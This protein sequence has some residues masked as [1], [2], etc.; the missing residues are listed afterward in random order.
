MKTLFLLGVFSLAFFGWADANR[1]IPI[2][3]EFEKPVLD[4]CSIDH[5]GN[6]WV[7][8]NCQTTYFP[9]SCDWVP[10]AVYR[11]GGGLPFSDNGPDE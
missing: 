2:P 10:C 6:V 9:N 8:Q 5:E 3:I 1:P 7:R 4:V 11:G